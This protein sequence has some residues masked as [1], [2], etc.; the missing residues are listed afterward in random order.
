MSANNWEGWDVTFMR[1]D[2]KQTGKH[3]YCLSLL[4]CA[5]VHMC[6][7]DGGSSVH[8]NEWRENRKQVVESRSRFLFVE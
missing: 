5:R 6:D 4:G 1:L 2:I 7:I 3:D 8:M